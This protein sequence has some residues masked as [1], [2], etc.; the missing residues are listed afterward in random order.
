MYE[1]GGD[2]TLNAKI[3]GITAS[4][5]LI[6]KLNSGMTF[7]VKPTDINTY[8]PPIVVGEDRRKGN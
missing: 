2:V 8:T 1:V 7:L 3:T 6:V 4:G 5:N